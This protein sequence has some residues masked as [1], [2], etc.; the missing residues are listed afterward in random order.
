MDDV[1]HE[2]TWMAWPTSSAIWGNLLPGVQEDVVRV[3]RAIASYEPVVVCATNPSAAADARA[4]CG[5]AVTVIDSIPVNDCWM[6][7]SGPVFRT[8]GGGCRD[9]VGLS[10]NGW[11]GKQNVSKD[12]F[13]ASEIAQ[14]TDLPFSVAD[15]VGEGGAVETDGDGTVMATQSSLVNANR[16]PAMSKAQVEAAVLDAYGAQKMLWVPG[17]KGRDITDDHIDATSR[18]VRPG[19]VMVQVPPR[20][21]TDIWAEDARQQLEILSRSVDAK[22]RRPQIIT[23]DGPRTVPSDSP[24]FLDSYVNFHVVNGAVITARFGDD[25]RDAACRS[26]LAAAFPGREIEQLRVDHLHAGGGGIHCITMQEPRGAG[27]RG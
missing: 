14:Y 17:L 10:F 22:G 1:P 19:V 18:F 27:S 4:R 9:T 16:N 7:D 26:T 2:R 23:M 25:K 20:N 11:G 15:F 3:A 6:R 12:R 5:N 8:D 21:R 13:V 24:D